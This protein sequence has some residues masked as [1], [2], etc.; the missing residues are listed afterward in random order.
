MKKNIA[1]SIGAAFAISG[2]INGA[3]HG[4]LAFAQKISDAIKQ[5]SPPSPAANAAV[6][7]VAPTA[8]A[9]AT[10]NVAPIALKARGDV[11][12]CR[13]NPRFVATKKEFSSKS[14]FST[15]E[16]FTKGLVDGSEKSRTWQHP[17]WQKFGWLAAIH[18]DEKGNIYTVPA[19]RIN[20]LDNKPAEQNRVFKV[21]SL[22]G[23]MSVFATLPAASAPNEQNPYGALAVAY[24]CESRLLYVSSIAGSTRS[25]EIGRIFAVE[26]DRGTVRFTRENLDAMGLHLFKLDNKKRLYYGRVR[27]PEIWSIAVDDK[28]AFVGEPRFE[29]SLEGMGPRGD[30]RARRINFTPSNEMIVWGIEFS[31]NLVAPTE[32]QESQYRFLYDAKTRKWVNAAPLPFRNNERENQN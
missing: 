24:D 1:I 4:E 9:N 27:E 8:A 2:A 5:P 21:D 18:Y 11:I 14:F 15:S 22:T 10:P 32:K 26:P 30:D 29:L 19:P 20:V 3:I 16:R 23:E 17:T 25:K 31:V 28:G 6:P 7:N 12:G 13:T